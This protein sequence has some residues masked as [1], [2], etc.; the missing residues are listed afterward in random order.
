MGT[1]LYYSR[2]VSPTMLPALNEISTQQS[3]PTAH[4]ITKCDRLLDYAATCPNV[5]IH[6]HVRDMILCGDTDAAYLVL[7]KARICIAGHFYLSDHPPPTDMPKPKLNVT[8]LTVYQT[9]KNLVAS[10]EE[11]E[12]GGM[13][14]KR[15]TMVPIRNTLVAMEH[16]QPENECQTAKQA[17]KFP[18]CL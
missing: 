5:V 8:T 3:K 13:F 4:T 2:E 9:L 11:A 14:L 1:L 7:P 12:T 17:L 15:H 18:A 10:A 16:L 6:Y